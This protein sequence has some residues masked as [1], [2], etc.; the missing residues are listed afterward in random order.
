MRP[1]NY[2]EI[3][4]G[5]D[6]AYMLK[7]HAITHCWAAFWSVY[8]PAELKLGLVS[9][10]IGNYRGRLKMKKQVEVPSF[11]KYWVLKKSFVNIFNKL[12]K[13]LLYNFYTQY[14]LNDEILTFSFFHFDSSPVVTYTTLSKA[15]NIL[16][17]KH[18]L[19]PINLHNFHKFSKK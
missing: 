12:S 16:L 17:L 13:F 15:K 19:L 10:S 3:F 14:F 8:S 4:S 2:Y 6:P 18:Y 5:Y 9:S 7:S 11:K 1:V